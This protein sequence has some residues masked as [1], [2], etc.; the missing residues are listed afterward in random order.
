MKIF[1]DKVRKVLSTLT[2]FIVLMKF[3]EFEE[4]QLARILEKLVTIYR[5]VETIDT[6]VSK[7]N[8]INKDID[9]KN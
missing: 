5:I 8:S 7:Y 2:I 6:L 1:S 4:N 3:V 9:L